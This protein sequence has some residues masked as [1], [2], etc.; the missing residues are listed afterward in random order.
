G[1]E[2]VVSE[3]QFRLKPGSKV[4]ALKPG[5]TPAAPTEAELKAAEQ[6]SGGGRRGGGPR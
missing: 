2:R 4:T 3:G 1:G 5:E 6:K